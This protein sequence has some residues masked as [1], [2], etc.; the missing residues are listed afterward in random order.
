[1]DTH[2]DVG[3]RHP[4]AMSSPHDETTH[5]ELPPLRLLTVGVVS[6]LAG[7]VAMATPVVI[8]DWIRTGHRALELPMAATSWLFGLNHF[9]DARNLWWPIVVGVVLLG[10]YGALSGVVFTSLVDR[11]LRVSRPGSIVAA[12][13]AWSFVSFTFFW[14]MLLPIARAGAPFR[15]SAGAGRLFAAPDWTWILGFTLLG[16]V[17][18][19]WYAALRSRPALLA[20]R[21]IGQ[22]PARLDHAA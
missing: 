4:G 18:A 8:W 9:S 3:S 12:G 15:A 6:G 21:R 14:Y 17:T 16:L 13:A 11:F 22:H 5:A 2:I 7:G 20:E 1:V 19:L 10:A